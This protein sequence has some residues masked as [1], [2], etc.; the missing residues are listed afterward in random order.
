[1]SLVF[2]YVFLVSTLPE[3]A[4][5]TQQEI[6]DIDNQLKELRMKKAELQNNCDNILNAQDQ[7]ISDGEHSLLVSSTDHELFTQESCD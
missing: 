1:M 2:L 5:A 4:A 6:D 7:K 3:E